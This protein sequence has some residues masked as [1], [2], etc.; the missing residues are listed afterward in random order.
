M[1]ISLEDIGQITA[2]VR[3]YYDGMVFGQADTLSRVFDPEARFQGFR[4]AVHVRRALP[5]FIA[6]TTSPD[7]AAD[8]DVAVRLIDITGSVAVVKV[9]DRFR[10]R[11]YVDYL[12]LIRSAE[13]WR[14]I[15]KAFT[16]V[17]S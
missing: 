9:Q 2:L 5:E 7:A 16:T 4:D 8:Y 12:T 15:N 13:S 3:D 17:D 14:I 1:V 10:G 6:M 11:L